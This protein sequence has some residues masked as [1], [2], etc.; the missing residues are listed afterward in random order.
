[1]SVGGDGGLKKH[2][3]LPLCFA[4]LIHQ[5][6]TPT[7]KLHPLTSPFPPPA[8]APADPAD[9]PPHPPPPPPPR[10]T[11]TR[12]E[13]WPSRPRPRL[14]P[15]QRPWPPPCEPPP[16]ASPATGAAPCPSPGIVRNFDAKSKKKKKKK[17]K[18][19]EEKE[20][21][22]EEEEKRWLVHI[23]SNSTRWMDSVSREFRPLLELVTKQVS[24]GGGGQAK[25]VA[26][27]AD[28]S[29]KKERRLTTR[30]YS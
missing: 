4:C 10:P 12:G 11:T 27:P 25:Q 21:E 8:L 23:E 17:K 3:P 28:I 26:R 30:Y 29:Q 9:P 15:G 6:T 16:A 20:E 18:K 14:T 7:P 22:E 13:K 5:P 2:P 24:T 1:M 19:E